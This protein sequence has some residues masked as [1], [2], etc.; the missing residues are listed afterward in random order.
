[1]RPQRLSSS[2]QLQFLQSNNWTASC[3]GA[4]CEMQSPEQ[5]WNNPLLPPPWR[6]QC[7]RPEPQQT[8]RVVL[9]NPDCRVGTGLAW[10]GMLWDSSHPHTSLPQELST[11]TNDFFCMT[12]LLLLLLHNL[13]SAVTFPQSPEGLNL[14]CISSAQGE[15]CGMG[16]CT[17]RAGGCFRGRRCMWGVTESA[18]L[19]M[20]EGRGPRNAKDGNK[21]GS[22]SP[23]PANFP[24]VNLRLWFGH[25]TQH[26]H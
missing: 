14:Q 21:K 26:W 12:S 18:D 24:D 10:C 9:P 8:P 11:V 2:Q 6:S 16:I 13:H 7:C 20:L 1:M 25:K 17:V 3:T 23:M 19:L 5:R 15:Q 4:P 22:W